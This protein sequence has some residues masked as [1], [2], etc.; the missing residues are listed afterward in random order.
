MKYVFFF[1]DDMPIYVVFVIQEIQKRV[2]KNIILYTKK[3]CF[4]MV[5]GGGRGQLNRNNTKHCCGRRVADA[6]GLR[7]GQRTRGKGKKKPP[8]ATRR[9]RARMPSPK[10]K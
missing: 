7:T 4:R 2:D 9:K 5:G 1:S 8:R 3:R 10:N 6:V